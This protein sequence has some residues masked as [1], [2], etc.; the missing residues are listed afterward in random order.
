MELNSRFYII[1]YF[2]IFIVL[3]IDTAIMLSY[4][5]KIMEVMNMED[6]TLTIDDVV[7]ICSNVHLEDHTLSF[8]AYGTNDVRESTLDFMYRHG[9]DVLDCERI[10]NNLKKEELVKGP[11]DNYLDASKPKLW[12]FLKKYLGLKLYVKLMIYNKR[13]RVAVVSLHD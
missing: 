13:R 3:S 2:N 7:Q 6:D 12:I 11:V 5:T 10:I 4:D 9:M 1:D 8:D